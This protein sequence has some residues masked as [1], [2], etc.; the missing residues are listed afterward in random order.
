MV[1][2]GGGF[3]QSWIWSSGSWSS[4]GSVARGGGGAADGF[5][6]VSCPTT[7]F[8][9][10]VLHDHRVATW[11]GGVWTVTPTTWDHTDVSCWSSTACGLAID[12]NDTAK[13][14]FERWTDGSIGG[15]VDIAGRDGAL[16]VSCPTSTCH[17]LTQAN[18]SVYVHRIS[19]GAT[20]TKWV[21]YGTWGELSCGSD[22]WCMA[23]AEAKYRTGYGSS[24]SAAAPAA[25]PHNAHPD[26]DMDLSCASRTSC[27]LVGGGVGADTEGGDALRWN[28]S[29]WSLRLIGGGTNTQRGRLRVG[30][31]L[32]GRRRTG[33]LQPLDRV[34]VDQPH[35]LRLH[36]GRLRL[37]RLPVR[38][39]VPGH[40]FVGERAGLV[41]WHLPATKALVGER[42]RRRL[43]RFHLHGAG[44]RDV[45]GSQVG[46]V[47]RSNPI[48]E[49]AL[50]STGVRQWFPVLLV[51][52]VQLLAVE[53]HRLV[54]RQV[55]PRR[56]GVRRGR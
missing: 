42:R 48:A 8:C 9:L 55:A 39:V 10:A 18:E 46:H 47:E 16:A 21:H 32:P 50:R 53:R 2:R 6:A 4:S 29:A 15:A 56:R 43:R 44:R 14:E 41:R 33:P 19:G 27:T 7:G 40:G 31:D 54:R 45:A 17:L 11:H 34:V 38:H 1:P 22:T 25:D 3:G 12:G 28:G 30:I 5:R 23:V 20:T 51:G 26:V 52:R 24:W 36:A 37:A 49:R 13:H 35:H